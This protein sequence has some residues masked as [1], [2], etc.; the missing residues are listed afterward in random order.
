MASTQDPASSYAH[1]W[2]RLRQAVE[3]GHPLAWLVLVAWGVWRLE[4]FYRVG[5]ATQ[6]QVEYSLQAVS[7]LW[8]GVLNAAQSQ[9]RVH[10]LFTKIVDMW[11]AGRPELW[12]VHAINIVVFALS[13]PCFALAVF[14]SRAER[15]LYVWLFASL[16]WASYH[17][18]PPAAYPT[19]V[20]LPFLVWA[21]AAFVVRRQSARGD[22]RR[23]GTVVGFGVL[24]FVAL[25]QYEPAAAMS[26]CVLGWLVYAEPRPALRKRLAIALG[27]AAL[28]YGAIYLGWRLRFPSAYEGAVAGSFSPWNVLRVVI[29]YSVGGLPFCEAYSDA[30]PIRFGDT[31][32]GETF[33]RLPAELPHAPGTY[34]VLFTALALFGFLR[35]YA[36]AQSAPALASR[37]LRIGQWALPPIL[38]L[39]IN[40]PL[41]LSA[42]YQGWVRDLDETYLTSQLALYPLVLFGTLVLAA[43]YRRLRVHCVPLAF[44]AL[45]LLV[46]ILSV[47]VRAHN[48]HVTSLQRANLARWEE[49]TALASY[50]SHIERPVV[51]PDL[52]YSIFMGEHDWTSY[53]GRYV[54]QRFGRRLSLHARPPRGNY[55]Y[56]LVRAYRFEDGRL[57]ALSVQA[58]EHVAIVARRENAPLAL[59]S[60]G[61][62]VPLDWREAEALGSSGYSAVT[63]SEPELRGVYRLIDPVW[64]WPQTSLATSR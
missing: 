16:A 11:L 23:W 1:R 51:A 44:G 24:A 10:S 18:M 58:P 42:K 27:C 26:L 41:G 29:A 20:H 55:N 21:L 31:H 53:W 36:A 19:F 38:L 39:A 56:A 54:Q 63:L 61:K 33:L 37:R 25:F 28:V 30:I 13:A 64:L 52:Y 50:A 60:A 2:A 17:H 14:R 45:A 62:G 35:V 4:P 43:L 12:R 47:P 59:V 57:R 49:V 46:A 40:G 8:R 48:W 34:V 7:H 22:E 32:V 5:M 15:L 3:R 6:D 9:G